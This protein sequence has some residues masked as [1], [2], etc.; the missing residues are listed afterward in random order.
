MEAAIRRLFTAA[1]KQEKCE[2]L[3]DCLTEGGTATVDA[4][5]GQVVMVSA[6]ALGHLQ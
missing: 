3:W 2:A 4:T 1:I 6:D 5:T